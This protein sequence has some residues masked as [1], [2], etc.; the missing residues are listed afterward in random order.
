[1]EPREREHKW[2]W[3]AVA[4]WWGL[5]LRGWSLHSSPCSQDYFCC[6]SNGC[7]MA[8]ELTVREQGPGPK[9]VSLTIEISA[10]WQVVQVSL[11]D[12]PVS[13]YCLP[14]HQFFCHLH[15]SSASVL[16]FLPDTGISSRYLFYHFF[17]IC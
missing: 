3:D 13:H 7:F 1:M 9:R 5:F 10:P 2:E 12:S 17:E 14:F 15:A 16:Y 8:N 11:C 6:V 4:Q